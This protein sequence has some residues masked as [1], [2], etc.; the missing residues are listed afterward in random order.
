M[1]SW[2]ADLQAEGWIIQDS[3]PSEHFP[4]YDHLVAVT[5]LMPTNRGP[6]DMCISP[7]RTSA[8]ADGTPQALANHEFNKR[9]MWTHGTNDEGSQ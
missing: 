5:A 6:L 2:T 3:F 1:M 8:Y 4:V 7:A 9:R